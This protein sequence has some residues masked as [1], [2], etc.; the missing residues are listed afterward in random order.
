MAGLG[1]EMV[2]LKE[3]Y[4]MADVLAKMIQAGKAS[5]TVYWVGFESEA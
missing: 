4:Y 5:K 3:F 1:G 2:P